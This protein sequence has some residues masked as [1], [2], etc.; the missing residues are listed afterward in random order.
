MLVAEV[1]FPCQRPNMSN[2][3]PLKE[4][5]PVIADLDMVSLDVKAGVKGTVLLLVE[6][7]V[8]SVIVGAKKKTW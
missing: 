6:G 1:D 7:L 3:S 5:L 4:P 2:L 8:A